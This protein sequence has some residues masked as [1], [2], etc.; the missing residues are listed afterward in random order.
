[1]IYHEAGE[2]AVLVMLTQTVESGKE[3]CAQYF[4]QDMENPTFE[5]SSHS[6]TEP[7][8]AHFSGSVTLLNTTYDESIRS[9]VSELEL[10]V[11][12][13]TKTVWH[14]L[15]A[16]WSDYGT[17][18]GPDRDALLNLMTA[19]AE[20]AKSFSN[21]RIVHCS[22]GVGRTGTFI[23]LD[24]LLRQLQSGQLLKE[25][26]NSADAVF[27]TVNRLREQRMLMVYNAFQYQFIYD[28][29]KEQT[30]IKLG[31]QSAPIEP[32]PQ[33]IAK[34]DDGMFKPELVALSPADIGSAAEP[35]DPESENNEVKDVG[36]SKE[37]KGDKE[38]DDNDKADD[39][40]DD[41]K[42]DDGEAEDEDES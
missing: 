34:P 27:N 23:A 9:H 32:R 39:D 5:F 42:D 41:N 35:D 7:P 21:P 31:I 13:N 14:F 12:S 33:K 2:V 4:P 1:M 18:E 20:K 38:N 24:H 29:L 40:D 36:R 15:F 19:T 11:G 25:D 37:S 10:R 30:Q 8:A 22:A 26:D 3:K 17:P 16:G 28:V 6:T